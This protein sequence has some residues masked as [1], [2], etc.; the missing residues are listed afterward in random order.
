M[1][2]QLFFQGQP[3]TA[4]A[5]AV[6]SDALVRTIDH[7]VVVNPSGADAWLSVW[8]VQ[9]GDTA[10][11]DTIIYHEK[12]IVS[13]ADPVTLSALINM[14]IPANATIHLQSQTA[15]A[16]TVTISGRS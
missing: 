10:A 5:E 3:G 2:K 14:A 9:D 13:V 7:A 1:T 4:S 11:D 15:T 6:T 8:L 16:L 12:N